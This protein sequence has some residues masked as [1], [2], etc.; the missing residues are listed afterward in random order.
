MYKTN[1]SFQER[2]DGV[3]WDLQHYDTYKGSPVGARITFAVNS[4]DILQRHPLAGVGTGDFVTEYA[5]V[6]ARTTKLG[7]TTN[8]HNMY[9]LEAVQFGLLGI[10]SL[11]SI[12]FAQWYTASRSGDPFQRRFGNVLP[13][14]FAVIMLSDTYLRGFFTTMLFVYLSTFTYRL[15]PEPAEE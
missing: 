15:W 11:V 9:T 2:V 10:L 3:V 1:G 5:K 4:F 14:I 7:A 12:L 13:V 8:P 6:D